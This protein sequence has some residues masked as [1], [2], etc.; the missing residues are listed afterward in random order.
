MKTVLHSVQKVKQKNDADR[1]SNSH[2]DFF[3]INILKVQNATK[4][5]KKQKANKQNTQNTQFANK[6]K[7]NTNL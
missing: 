3:A 6:H 5:Q 2:F 4:T 7:R 1:F